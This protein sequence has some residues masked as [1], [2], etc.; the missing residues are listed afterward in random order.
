MPSSRYSRN[1]STRRRPIRRMNRKYKR[2]MT[3][4]KVKRIVGAELKHVLFG[5]GYTDVSAAAAAII[6]IT[7]PI[8]IG[9]TATTRDGN[10][11]KPVNFHGYLS[12]KG[13]DGAAATQYGIRTSV[14]RWNED[15]ANNAISAGKVMEDPASPASPFNVVNTGSFKVL[16][17]RYFQVINSV[18]NP[19]F[20]Q[21]RKFY[22]R[23]SSAPKITYTGANAKKYHYFL[24]ITSDDLS[25][26]QHPQYLIDAFFR[27]T[28]S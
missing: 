28:D 16:W 8:P 1:R 2:P 9:D 17:T 25:A 14:I 21:T 23:L 22:V 18:N 15:Q 5:L 24:L 6:E 4:G 7:A 11:I 19:K 26:N 3:V 27:F 20:V 12:I 10:W 13:F